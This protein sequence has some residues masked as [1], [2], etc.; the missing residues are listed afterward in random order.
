MRRW[1]FIVGSIVVLL[2]IG[3]AMLDTVACTDRAFACENPCSHMGYREWV[4]GLRP[5]D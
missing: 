3:L 4:F 1:I 5:G 2:A